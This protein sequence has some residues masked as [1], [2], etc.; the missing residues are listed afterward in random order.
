MVVLV[1]HDDG[2]VLLIL[3]DVLRRAVE[4]VRERRPV[5]GTTMHGQPK[6][7]G[8]RRDGQT[9]HGSEPTSA[10]PKDR[11]IFSRSC[12]VFNGGGAQICQPPSCHRLIASNG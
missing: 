10:R 8:D 6:G 4:D 9:F 12:R 7:D 2:E 1:A 3:L 11:A 5:A